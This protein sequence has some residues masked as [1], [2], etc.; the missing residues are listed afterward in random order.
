[1]SSHTLR[2]NA[3]SAHNFAE[4]EAALPAEENPCGPSVTNQ[5]PAKGSNGMMT[6]SVPP[7]PRTSWRL[8]SPM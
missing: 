5:H 7:S 1:M 6:V 3:V 4:M 8:S 2:N